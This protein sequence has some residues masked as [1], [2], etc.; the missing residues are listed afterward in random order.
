[1]ED[2]LR[3]RS[4]ALHGLAGIGKSQIATEFVYQSMKVFRAIFWVSAS[5][6]EKLFQ[7]YTDIA[8]ELNLSSGTT[9]ND[10]RAIVQL[11]NQW[12]MSTGQSHSVSYEL[13]MRVFFL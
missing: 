5:S 8:R 6:T 7:G 9:I 11:V 3:L 1:M 13:V 2:T 4:F 12:L 10:Q